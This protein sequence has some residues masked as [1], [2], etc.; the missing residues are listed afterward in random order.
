MNKSNLIDMFGLTGDASSEDR[1]D[2]L[3]FRLESDGQNALE[4]NSNAIGLSSAFTIT[5]SSS[6]SAVSLQAWK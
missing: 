2:D 1:L 3:L 5:I 4:A 6:G